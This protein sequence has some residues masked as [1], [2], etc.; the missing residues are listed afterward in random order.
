MQLGKLVSGLSCDFP[1]GGLDHSDK[2]LFQV[3]TSVSAN[4]IA[5]APG[6]NGAIPANAVEAGFDGASVLYVCRALPNSTDWTPGK[7]IFGTCHVS[8]GGKELSFSNYEILIA[9]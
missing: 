8:Y 1:W 2:A 9:N 5:W 7:F 3:L 6:S 4:S